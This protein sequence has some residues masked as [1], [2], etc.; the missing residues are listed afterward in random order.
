[1]AGH[2]MRP[3]GESDRGEHE[4]VAAH[5]TVGE[6]G[7][8]RELRPWTIDC[9][10]VGESGD[11]G[12]EPGGRRRG[13]DE[14]RSGDGGREWRCR[15]QSRAP[16]PD[17]LVAHPTPRPHPHH[18]PTQPHARCW[19]KLNA[20]LRFSSGAHLPGP[21]AMR[22]ALRAPHPKSA[23]RRD[24]MTSL[25]L[26]MV[27]L[28]AC[29]Y[30]AG[31]LWQDAEVRHQLIST[32]PSVRVQAKDPLSMD[33]T[34]RLIDCK[35]QQKKLVDAELELAAARS[36]GYVL[37]N[38][39][40]LDSH[41]TVVVGIFTSFGGQTRRTASRKNW[42]PTGAA[43]K[44]LESD[45][46]IIIRYVIG[47]SSNRGDM[48]DRQIDQENSE[49][50][51]FLILDDHVESDDDLTQKTRLFFSKAVNAWNADFYVKMDDNIGLNLDM[52]VTMLS[53]HG[54]KPRVYVG[55]MKSGTVVS[56]PNAQWYE[57]DWWK[58]GDQKS[59]YH[60]H[61]AGQVYGL[62]RSL[63]QY[64]TINSAFLK[65][66][67]NEDVAVGAWMLGLNAELVDDRNLC[68]AFNTGGVCWTQ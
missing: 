42:V 29:L 46:G 54:D 66:Y 26:L 1:M 3:R 38:K 34:L 20:H 15:S 22:P 19:P 12:E 28:F 59:E 16:R 50:K 13:G 65:D 31:R 37:G 62:S 64:I 6:R 40:N 32:D 48:L 57:P 45:K 21:R 53:S 36:Q 68:C 2:D 10:T 14:A 56:D 49:T 18:P 8:A 30:I 51:D 52:V 27:S 63:A 5:Q 7:T 24:S 39:T 41:K 67:K 25:V 35:E 47:R 55:C 44:E 61:A 17:A 33:E 58:F 9:G 43:L 4:T 23:L 11:R 60:R